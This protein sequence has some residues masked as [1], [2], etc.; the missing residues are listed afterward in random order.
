M[1][2]LHAGQDDEVAGR[3]RLLELE[4]SLSA[5]GEEFLQCLDVRRGRVGPVPRRPAGRRHE[6]EVGRLVDELEIAADVAPHQRPGRLAH[7]LDQLAELVVR[8]LRMCHDLSTP[9]GSSALHG[10]SIQRSVRRQT[11]S[12]LTT[13][14]GFS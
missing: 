2:P 7:A 3:V 13:E 14:R 6:R 1:L 12:Q 4:D 9:T 8:D 10:K 11:Y 5:A